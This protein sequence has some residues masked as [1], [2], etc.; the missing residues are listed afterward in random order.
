MNTFVAKN[1]ILFTIVPLFILFVSASY[2]RF[3]VNEE[4]M[5]TY[6][7][8]CDA[9]TSSCFVG[10]S[11]DTCTEDYFY[12]TVEKNA[13]DLRSQCGISILNCEE[14]TACQLSDSHCRIVFCDPSEAEQ[15]SE[16]NSGTSS[17][18]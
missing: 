9:N 12:Y 15:C 14:A 3:V 2:L 1:I 11:D 16:V 17:T 18:I 4:Y 8:P 7:V 13:H 10:C 6:E 5:V